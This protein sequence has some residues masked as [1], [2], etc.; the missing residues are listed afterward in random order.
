VIDGTHVRACVSQENQ[1]SFIDKKD[2]PTQNIM[3]S[4]SFDMQFTFIWA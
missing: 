3:A 1:I 2:I 4:C